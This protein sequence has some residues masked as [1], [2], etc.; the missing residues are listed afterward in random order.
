M[1][2][3]GKTISLVILGSKFL[4]CIECFCG[5]AIAHRLRQK[6][7][8]PLMWTARLVNVL[9]LPLGSG[10]LRALVAYHFLRMAE[11]QEGENYERAHNL[12]MGCDPE[13]FSVGPLSLR[14]NALT[15]LA[16]YRERD[17][18]LAITKIALERKA[19]I[20]NRKYALLLGGACLGVNAEAEAET[21]FSDC[22]TEHADADGGGCLAGV[23]PVRILFPK[24][25][26]RTDEAG[27]CTFTLPGVMGYFPDTKVRV[28]MPFEGCAVVENAQVAGAFSI[29][30]DQ[31]SIVVYDLAGHPQHD[32]VAGHYSL[33]KGSSLA[34]DRAVMYYPYKA[35]AH[36]P[37]AIHLAGRS[38]D[39]YF[40]WMVEYLP[41]MLN[42][43]EAGVPRGTP[44]IAPANIPKTMRRALELVNDDYFSIH[45]HTSDTLLKVDRL[46]VPSMQSFIVDGHSLPFWMIGALSSRHLRFVRD[47]ILQHIAKDS[48][49]SRFP[50]RVFLLRGNRA[51][52]VSTEKKIRAALEREGFI[53]LDPAT[54]CF[55]DQ[56]RLFRDAKV[57]VGGSGAGFANLMFCTQ[58][59][60]VLA[61]IGSHNEDFTLFS[62]LFQA[63]A[64]GRYTQILGEPEMSASSA[65][66][67]DYYVHVNFSIKMSDVLMVLRRLEETPRYPIT[68]TPCDE[69]GVQN[70]PS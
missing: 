11:L 70:C 5:P 63:V 33:M 26:S 50:E 67:Q 1:L 66:S 52:V 15:C 51:R 38:F 17:K 60:D 42:A 20:R 48:D 55:E 12:L 19:H 7:F 43:I 35:Q 54:L 25:F 56:V 62:N 41:R 23:F 16:A 13:V 32:Y 18:I 3:L 2:I 4:K 34:M 29:L 21:L 22:R 45:W 69:A 9:R 28:P 68:Q 61:F 39:N 31:G 59:P 47:R 65:V 14:G 10:L 27:S 53:S 24:H 30:D 49:H 40:H 46:Y 37:S 36:L 57:I 58:S 8:V 6:I 64:G 44:L